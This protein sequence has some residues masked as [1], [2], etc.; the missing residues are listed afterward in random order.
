MYPFS[1]MYYPS[2]DGL[3]LR[4]LKCFRLSS[5][6]SEMR[7]FSPAHNV[8]VEVAYSPDTSIPHG[9]KQY[10]PMRNLA[11]SLSVVSPQFALILLW[12]YRK[13]T[14][15]LNFSTRLFSFTTYFGARIGPK[16]LL[17][18]PLRPEPSFALR[19]HS[20]NKILVVLCTFVSF[21]WV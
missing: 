16:Q 2:S 4:Y 9:S 19:R 17:L 8:D 15:F 1:A 13:I 12:R 18:T 10:R 5:K 21:G 6:T 20:E 14:S 3:N 11:G 7:L